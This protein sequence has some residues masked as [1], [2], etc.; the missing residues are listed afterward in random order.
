[1]SESQFLQSHRYNA[2]PV[3]KGEFEKFTTKS[4]KSGF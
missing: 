4:I 1:M 2:W 3:E